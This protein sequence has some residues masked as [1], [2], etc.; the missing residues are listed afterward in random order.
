[1]R[2]GI[3]R[4]ASL[5]LALSLFAVPAAAQSKLESLSALAHA[6]AAKLPSQPGLVVFV[7]PPQWQAAAS[8]SA[9]REKIGAELAAAL[10]AADPTSAIRTPD[11]TVAA[12]R[13]AGFTPLDTLLVAGQAPEFLPAKRGTNAAGV[14]GV[15]HEEGGKLAVTAAAVRVGGTKPFARFTALLSESAEWRAL[16]ALPEK[17]IEAR[18]GVYL[19]SYGGV[20]A[21]SCLECRGPRFTSRAVRSGT[22][23]PV[24]LAIT[25]GTDGAV[26]GATVLRGLPGSGLDRSAIRAV[27][28]WRFRPAPG[29]QGKPVPVRM[30]VIVNFRMMPGRPR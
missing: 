15:M 8:H 20:G 6:L 10:A 22:G 19:A 3:V 16:L 29:P 9:L 7:A 27:R 13:H 18:D 25:I 2:Y 30:A 23:G 28:A 12:L 21:P 1:M 26:T 5:I 24:M 17:P 14:E 11:E 4:R